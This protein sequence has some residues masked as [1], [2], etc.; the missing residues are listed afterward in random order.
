VAPPSTQWVMWWHMCRQSVMAYPQVRGFCGAL[1]RCL[2]PSSWPSGQVPSQVRSRCPRGPLVAL[3]SGASCPRR[4]AR[5]VVLVP[6]PR[7]LVSSSSCRA[8][9]PACRRAVVPSWLWSSCRRRALW[10]CPLVVPSCRRGGRAPCPRAPL[11]SSCPLPRRAVV[12]VPSCAC[13]CLVPQES[14]RPD[15]PCPTD[16]RATANP[17]RRATGRGTGRGGGHHMAKAHR[18]P[19]VKDILMAAG[20]LPRSSHVVIEGLGDKGARSQR[21][22]ETGL[23]PPNSRHVLPRD[24]SSAP[25]L[26][27]GRGS[28]SSKPDA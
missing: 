28:S 15:K 19:P 10:S 20:S 24:G 4:L 12:V 11:P 25:P 1:S 27:A 23:D 16:P 14:D 6:C 26:R 13:P 9:V 7:A 18:G 5:A 8:V 17:A 2:V 22:A 21:H 3:P